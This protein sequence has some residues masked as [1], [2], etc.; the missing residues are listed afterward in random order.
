MIVPHHREAVNQCQIRSY[1]YIYIYYVDCWDKLIPFLLF[2]LCNVA[3]ES[4]GISPYELVYGRRLRELLD[5]TR[6]VW[7]NGDPAATQLRMPM[8]KYLEQLQSNLEKAFAAAYQHLTLNVDYISC[9]TSIDVCPFY[10]W[11]A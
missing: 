11:H 2:A 5:V 10:E 7:T 9:Y 6:T 4:T 3:H 1:I 8:T